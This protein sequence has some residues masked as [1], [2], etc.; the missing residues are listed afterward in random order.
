MIEFSENAFCHHQLGDLLDRIERK[1]QG[2][3]A[4]LQAH[5]TRENQLL[6]QAFN[7]DI[8]TGD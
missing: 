8:G 3:Q 7:D 6:L 1:F 4:H 5:E 2:F